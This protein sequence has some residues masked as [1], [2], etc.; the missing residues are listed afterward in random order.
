MI[1]LL[2][3]NVHKVG[4]FTCALV[5]GMWNSVKI[6]R[7]CDC[8]WHNIFVIFFFVTLVGSLKLGCE[9][10]TDDRNELNSI[11]IFKNAL[12]IELLLNYLLNL[13]KYGE[14]TVSH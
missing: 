14:N 1:L 3:Y 13:V 8:M 11:T 10:A 4:I 6:A 2:N 9:H 5:I 7:K 12:V